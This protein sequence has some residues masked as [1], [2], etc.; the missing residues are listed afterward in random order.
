M[1]CIWP[2]HVVIIRTTRICIEEGQPMSARVSRPG[3]RSFARGRLKAGAW[4]GAASFAAGGAQ[5]QPAVDEGGAGSDSPA[6]V[7]EV[8]GQRLEQGLGT[9]YTAPLLETPQTITLVPREI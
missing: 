5:A 6:D 8:I 4:L 9:R 2:A 7:V 3:I 1:S